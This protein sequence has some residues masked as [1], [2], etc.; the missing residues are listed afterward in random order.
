MKTTPMLIVVKCS[1]SINRENHKNNKSSHTKTINL[2][3][4]NN[5]KYGGILNSNRGDQKTG[6]KGLKENNSSSRI[7]YLMKISF[8]FKA[9]VIQLST[10][11][12]RVWR[13]SAVSKLLRVSYFV[14]KPS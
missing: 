2:R 14:H 5:K 7:L 13:L 3:R 8:K 1:K 4:S 6:F 10:L 9:E 11:S 12:N